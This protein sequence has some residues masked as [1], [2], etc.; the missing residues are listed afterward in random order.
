[1]EE[2]VASIFMAETT[3]KGMEVAHIGNVKGLG[4]QNKKME[5]ASSSKTLVMI[6]CTT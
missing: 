1:L 6:S 3:T 4:Q 2:Y 5:A